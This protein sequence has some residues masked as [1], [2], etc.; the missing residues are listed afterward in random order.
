MAAASRERGCLPWPVALSAR[1]L[2]A[3]GSH[4]GCVPSTQGQPS[5]LALW[6]MSLE[7]SEVRPCNNRI[8]SIARCTLSRYAEL[9]RPS[10]AADQARTAQPVGQ[11]GVAWSDVMPTLPS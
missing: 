7:A 1:R 6:P 9:A 2:I 4:Q 10:S 11:Q 5:S 8:A 3:V